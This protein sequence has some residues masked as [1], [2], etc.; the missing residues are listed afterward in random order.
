MHELVSG[1]RLFSMEVVD[2]YHLIVT[3]VSCLLFLCDSLRCG[4]R[5]VRRNWPQLNTVAIFKEQICAEAM[6]QEVV[7]HLLSTIYAC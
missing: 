4:L 1:C 6:L 2:I 5:L 3:V 7:L